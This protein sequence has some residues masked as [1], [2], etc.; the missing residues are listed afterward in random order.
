MPITA[1]V[2]Q[3]VDLRKV[4]IRRSIREVIDSPTRADRTPSTYLA[5]TPFVN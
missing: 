4:T 1:I 2:A 5:R 3:L